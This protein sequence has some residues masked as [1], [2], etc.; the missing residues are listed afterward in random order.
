MPSE[1]K[2]R[3]HLPA[4]AALAAVIGG[5]TAFSAG[6]QTEVA[7]GARPAWVI[8]PSLSGS[9]TLTDNAR[10]GLGEK[11]G[12]WITS[13]TPAVR[14]DGKGGRVSGH[15]DFA[16]QQNVYARD[17]RYDNDQK[18]L[19]ANGKA[20]LID[21]WL[22]LDAAASISQGATSV[23]AAQAVGNELASANR[24]ETRSYQWSPYLQGRLLGQLAYEL[25]Y[26]NTQTNANT[27]VYAS[28][29]GIETDAW[30]AQLAGGTP[31]ALLG[32]SLSAED[33]RTRV[34][35]RDFESDRLFGRLEYRYDPQLKFHLGA[36]RESD[37]F[38]NFDLRRRTATSYGFD[39]APTERSLLKFS[40]DQRS[41]GSGHLFSFEHRTALTAWKLLDS[42][43]VV[44]PA[45]Q[46][47]TAPVATAY[48]L[49]YNLLGNDPTLRNDP[50]AR[51]LATAQLLQGLGIPA[52]QL[53]YANI[54]ATQPFVQRQQQ[55]SVS[56]IGANN[57][58]TLT[59]QRS[60]NTRL[61][62]ALGLPGEDFL[63]N[64]NIRQTGWSASWAHRLTPHSSLTLN[65]LSSRNRG[66]TTA[67]E[68]Q[69]RSLNLLYTTKLGAR[70]TA[71]L[72]LRRNA[73]DGSGTATADYTEHAVVGTLSASF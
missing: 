8:T 35:G 3:C 15:F 59:A 12:D 64:Q 50:I 60:S 44:V 70:T 39:W 45:Q 43:T 65:A 71:S 16:W 34:Q 1:R 73:F 30:S 51:A 23:F 11:Q 41:F 54:A 67:T 37:N 36:G 62:T 40:K 61:G 47:T 18:R 25:R 2:H 4:S 48:D 42:R 38:S 31:L 21:E 20:E 29:S 53:I 33:Q 58:V 17:S 56:L 49:F 14:I 6:A 7:G 63:N 52:D 69:L 9:V 27:G 28:G 32:W 46:F 24:S 19:A 13:V 26:R 22:F 72:G 57:T 10:P 55:A 68:S 66:D 5:L